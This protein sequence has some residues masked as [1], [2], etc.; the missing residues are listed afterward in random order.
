MMAINWPI[1]PPES[2]LVTHCSFEL[3]FMARP[4]SEPLDSALQGMHQQL[5]HQSSISERS[6]PASIPVRSSQTAYSSAH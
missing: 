1:T 5:V 6:Q 2:K 3:P 4:E